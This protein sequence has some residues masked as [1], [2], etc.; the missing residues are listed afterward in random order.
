MK[1]NSTLVTTEQGLMKSKQVA[2]TKFF[3]VSALTQQDLHST[4]K[5]ALAC[6]MERPKKKRSSCLIL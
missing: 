4:F 1:T 3:E 5:E 2:A 6:A